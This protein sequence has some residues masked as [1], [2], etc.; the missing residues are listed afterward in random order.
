[1]NRPNLGYNMQDVVHKQIFTS[2]GAFILIG[3]SNLEEAEA[4]SR[5]SCLKKS[6]HGC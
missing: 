2:L 3:G 6:K 1:M 5:S 4:F